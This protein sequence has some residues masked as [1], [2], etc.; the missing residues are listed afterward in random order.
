RR[1]GRPAARGRS[2]VRGLV[3]SATVSPGAARSPM[4]RTSGGL[5]AFQGPTWALA[6]TRLVVVQRRTAGLRGRHG[7]RG[8]QR[9]TRLLALL[10]GLPRLVTSRGF[11]VVQ[12]LAGI[13][14]RERDAD[15]CLVGDSAAPRRGRA[16]DER[17][18]HHR[19]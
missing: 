13:S 18:P 19:D 17:D 8:R 6:V 5:T 16:E 2:P 14:V 9:R 7:G 10:P 3:S 15:P 11:V 4:G 12:R 1:G